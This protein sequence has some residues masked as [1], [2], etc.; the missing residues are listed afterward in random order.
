MMSHYII[1]IDH[2]SIVKKFL[3]VECTGYFKIDAPV[4]IACNY[5][6]T[7]QTSL[8]LVSPN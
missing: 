2:H 1:K 3:H 7:V 8:Y 6:T 5:A 4:L